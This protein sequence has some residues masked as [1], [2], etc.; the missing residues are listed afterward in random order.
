ML[1]TA[2]CKHELIR[3]SA[4]TG[5]T[6]QL[7]NR[8]LRLLFQGEPPEV[9]L[10]TTFTRK[11]A[12]EILARV[13]ARL[14]AAATDPRLLGQLQAALPDCAPQHDDCLQLLGQITAQLHRLRVST[15]DSF[16]SQLAG[17]FS[18]EL[19]LSPGWRIVEP[20]IDQALRSRAVDQVLAGDSTTDLMTLVH[21][22]TRGETTRSLQR[23]VR[24]KVDSLYG[25]Y[26]ASTAETW[27]LVPRGRPLK[28]DTL[29]AAIEALQA[30]ALPAHKTWHT[31]RD[32]DVAAARAGDWNAL[33]KKGIAG[34]IAAAETTYCRKPIEPEVVAAYQPLIQHAKAMLL[35]ALAR[36]TEATY[37]LLDKFHA[38]YERLKHAAHV[39]SFADI[40]WRLAAA[41]GQ[42]EAESIALRLDARLR[43]LLL[44]EFQDTSLQQWSVLRPL[45]RWVTEARS[46]H[47]FFCVGDAKQAIYGWRGGE[48]EIF[49]AVEDEL[50]G[51]VDQ[52]LDTSW[53]SAPVIIEVVNRIF[54]HLDQHAN[55]GALGPAVDAWQAQFHHQRVAPAKK[56]LPGYACLQAARVAQTE[57]GESQHDATLRFAAEQVARWRRQAP[58]F[59]IGVLVRRNASVRRLIYELRE[60]GIEASEEGGSLLDDSAAVQLVR[61]LI[62]LADHPADRVARFHLAHSDLATLLQQASVA[63]G[64]SEMLPDPASEPL[65]EPS[66]VP[67]FGSSTGGASIGGASTGSPTQP[68]SQPSTQPEPPREPAGQAD[69]L[70]P[71][72]AAQLG[73]EIRRQLMQYGYGRTVQ[74]WARRLAPDCNERE[75]RRLEKLIGLAYQYDANAT[76][77]PGDFLSYLDTQ[78]VADPL[79]AAVRVMTVH[80]AKGLEFDLVVLADLD[81]RLVGQPKELLVGRPARTAPIDRVCRRPSKEVLELLPESWRQLSLQADQ[82]EVAEALCVLYVAVTRSIHALQMIVAPSKGNEG[83]L[84]KTYGGLLRA[85]LT[86]GAPLAPEKLAYELGDPQ[87]Y[88]KSGQAGQRAEPTAVA[89]QQKQEQESG[90]G[91]LEV[92]LAPAAPARLRGLE[93][94]SPSG[95]EG[96]THVRL[97]ASSGSEDQRRRAALQRGTLVHA[98]FEQIEWLDNG[99]PGADRLRQVAGNLPASA[100][101]GAV[102]AAGQWEHW[103]AEFFGMLQHAPIAACLRRQAYARFED[104]V[105]RVENERPIAVRQGDRLLVGSIDRLVT[106]RRAGQPVAAEILDY[107]TDAL[108]DPNDR[109]KKVAFYRPQMEAYR[110]A[111]G[112][113]FQLEAERI[114]VKLLFVGSGQVEVM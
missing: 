32:K 112:Q 69:P 92:A 6:Y 43:H 107:K 114:S 45:A 55:L 82:Q 88:L 62:Q 111:V 108:A 47:S 17:S 37:Q 49:A 31:N 97:T 79:A 56:N 86:E 36:Q 13:L 102:L 89:R 83:S 22:L 76:S 18:L 1:T 15:L 12:G 50:P 91:S 72:A 10:A 68:S 85:A 84:H 44:D 81:T 21:A 29:A 95:L 57:A 39:L 73:R 75:L 64:A 26:R 30:V 78:K 7:T 52:P 103:L 90:P 2:A 74:A 93:R 101:A 94:V 54:E 53:R 106:V 71:N 35:N 98:W 80:Q 24:D 59:G 23:E 4:G 104:A 58:G 63:E 109:K 42:L 87:W 25:T 9:I 110:S 67:S 34:K 14:A 38:H 105:L 70:D 33:V 77:R 16:F 65:P 27:H 19:G 41:A 113:I 48:A 46:E 3:A 11:A 96:G 28:E 100:M 8:Y 5:K 99:L 66:P 61:S 51:V 20:H 40:T 60:L